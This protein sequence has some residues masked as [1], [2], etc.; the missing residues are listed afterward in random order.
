[1]E[2]INREGFLLTIY[3]ENR[4]FPFSGEKRKD[5]D[6]QGSLF[7]DSGRFILVSVEWVLSTKE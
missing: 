2:T 6:E 5:S 3:T 1:M 4:F 7:E